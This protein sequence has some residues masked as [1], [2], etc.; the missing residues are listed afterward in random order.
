MSLYNSQEVKLWANVKG[1][2]KR[3]SLLYEPL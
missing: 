1:V 3:R 2:E